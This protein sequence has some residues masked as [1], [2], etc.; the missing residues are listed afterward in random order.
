MASPYDP[1]YSNTLSRIYHY[2]DKYHLDRDKA[3]KQLWQE[4]RFKTN[5]VSPVGAAGIAQFMPATA[6]E[7]GVDVNSLESSLDGWGRYMRWILDRS[8]I[9]GDYAKALAAY[10]WGIGNVQRKGLAS[11]PEE[12]M[13]Y[14]NTILGKN[15][16]NSAKWS[17]GIGSILVLGFATYFLYKNLN[18]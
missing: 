18:A 1:Q 9:A 15:W 2:A 14:L 12:T 7:W 11:L 16:K 6:K 5:A 3:V 4:S 10:N 13:Q 17:L 8:Y